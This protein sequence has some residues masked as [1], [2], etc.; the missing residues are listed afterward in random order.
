MRC[1]SCLPCVAKGLSGPSATVS[2]HCVRYQKTGYCLL[3]TAYCLARTAYYLLRAYLRAC[4]RY[5]KAAAWLGLGLG[6]GIG[7]GIGLG[8]GL[9]PG[10]E[11]ERAAAL[12]KPH[13]SYWP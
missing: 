9:G 7:I 13:R 4:V 6:L 2:N 8:L 5:Q 11:R 1:T 12:G 10:L 3:L